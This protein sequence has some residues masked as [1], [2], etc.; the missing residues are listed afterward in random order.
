M[1]NITDSMLHTERVLTYG[2]PEFETIEESVMYHKWFL[3]ACESDCKN[4]L[5]KIN[6]TLSQRLTEIKMQRALCRN[7]YDE[8]PTAD[9]AIIS[10]CDMPFTDDLR[11]DIYNKIRLTFEYLDKKKEA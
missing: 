10:I 8:Y 2:T 9:I 3:E 6:K 11:K 4:L 5:S 7:L 1:N